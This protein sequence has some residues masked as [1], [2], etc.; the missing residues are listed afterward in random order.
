MPKFNGSIILFIN[1][2]QY[3]CS[4]FKSFIVILTILLLTWLDSEGA[5]KRQQSQG[6]GKYEP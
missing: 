1:V 5:E 6:K 2:I 4:L 3:V